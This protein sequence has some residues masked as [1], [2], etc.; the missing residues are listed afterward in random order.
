MSFIQRLNLLLNMKLEI[1]LSRKVNRRKALIF[2]LLVFVVQLAGGYY[3]I[4]RWMV[5]PNRN[6][7]ENKIYKL[8]KN[9]IP[10]NNSAKTELA[11]AYYL[12]EDLGKAEALLREILKEEPANEKA[13][14][15]LGLILSEQ[16]KYQD[17]IGLLDVYITKHQGVETRLAYLNL[18]HDY[19]GL[20][21]YN[22]ALKYYKMA[23][24]R[25]PG[26]PIVHY[27]LGQTYE[28]L[29]DKLNAL[30]SYQTALKIAGNYQE[31]D[32]ALKNLGKLDTA[33]G[34]GL[35]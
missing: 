18:G 20:G 2:L 25:D 6:M 13:S 3:I 9:S 32:Q 30:Y 29:Q 16:K 33:K 26:N 7:Y 35:N 31:A 28:K 15:Y 22:L 8:S 10:K 27:S 24:A 21:N 14:L 19:F 23:A 12:K 34:G 17:S 5:V 1:N 11:M 4:N